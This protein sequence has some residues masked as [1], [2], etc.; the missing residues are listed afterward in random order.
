MSSSLHT[1]SDSHYCNSSLI[2]R[3]KVASKMENIT[4]ST[5]SDNMP[6]VEGSIGVTSQYEQY[7]GEV[8]IIWGK[9]MLAISPVTVLANGIVL[10]A[11]A[12]S[13]TLRDNMNNVFIAN[14]ALTDL[15]FGAFVSPVMGV[16]AQIPYWPH[17]DIPCRLELWAE[18]CIALA[19][20]LS[21][22]AFSISKYLYIAYPL[23]FELW[24]T[25]SVTAGIVGFC[26]LFPNLILVPGFWAMAKGFVVGYDHEYC[27]FEF[28]RSWN[29]IIVCIAIIPVLLVAIFGSKIL[30]IA[31]RHRKRI[32]VMGDNSV[33][34]K[35]SS[36]RA[37]R[38][39]IITILAFF[40]LQAPLYVGTFVHGICYCVPYKWFYE[41][42][43]YPFWLCSMVNPFIYFFSERYYRV[44]FYKLITC[45]KY[46]SHV[47]PFFG[48][49]ETGSDNNRE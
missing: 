43:A 35:R 32:A 11:I 28:T 18:L 6:T 25:K 1:S 47:D 15:C 40:L 10:A 22:A 20:N 24:M 48:N 3:Y 14:L 9:I 21:L 4:E 13:R 27:E 12:S 46:T 16:W 45:G 44:S 7:V 38:L 49:S 5:S 41:Y 30:L 19:S 42:L 31:H 17:G 33:E 8:E 34:M 29:I 37:L 36:W 26:W 2:N 23:H 39:Y